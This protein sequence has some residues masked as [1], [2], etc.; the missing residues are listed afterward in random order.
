MLY[1]G[2]AGNP[3]RR[4]DQ[5]AGDKPWWGQVSHIALEHYDS[6]EDALSAERRAIVAERPLHNVMH[7]SVQRRVVG[8]LRQYRSD[9][10]PWTLG[11]VEDALRDLGVGVGTSPAAAIRRYRMAHHQSDAITDSTIRRA[12]RNLCEAGYPAAEYA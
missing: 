8:N 10:P 4:F 7:N 11:I 1:I 5:H 6:R 9:A 2:I 3:G 12:H